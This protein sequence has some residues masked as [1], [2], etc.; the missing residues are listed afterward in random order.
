MSSAYGGNTNKVAT[1]QAGPANSSWATPDELMKA[2]RMRLRK[3]WISELDCI[4][5]VKSGDKVFVFVVKDGQATVLEDSVDLFPS[6]ALTAQ[7]KLL[8]G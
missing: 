7:L 3:S 8:I 5:A 4:Q 1:A 6:D 2:I